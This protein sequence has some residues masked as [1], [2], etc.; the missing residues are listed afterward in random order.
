MPLAGPVTALTRKD[1][2]KAEA[3]YP[4]RV[5]KQRNFPATPKN[6]AA[7][8]YIAPKSLAGVWEI[9]A[10]HA[11]RLGSHTPAKDLGAMQAKG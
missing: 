3:R 9:Q 10:D 6:S 2:A 8:A 7:R 1:H 5:R 4:L 11:H